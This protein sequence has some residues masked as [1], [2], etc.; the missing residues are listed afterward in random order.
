[1]GT[2]LVGGLRSRYLSRRPAV[3]RC[4]C[5]EGRAFPV[6]GS[7]HG[8]ISLSVQHFPVGSHTGLVGTCAHKHPQ[9]SSR[10]R[11]CCH[12]QVAD[13]NPTMEA[14]APWR[15]TVDSTIGDVF[16]QFP[17]MFLVH[18]LFLFCHPA[19]TKEPFQRPLGS[20]HCIVALSLQCM[21]S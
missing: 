12:P 9:A 5:S 2:L 14:S 8:R 13:S 6:M 20:L 21:P 17:G 15:H 4:S 7:Q 16:P 1:M 10:L 11:A 18:S 3:W 19:S